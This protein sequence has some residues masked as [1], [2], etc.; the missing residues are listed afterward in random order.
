MK[1][2][3]VNDKEIMENDNKLNSKFA[4]ENFS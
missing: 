4:S 2:C 3:N 1:I